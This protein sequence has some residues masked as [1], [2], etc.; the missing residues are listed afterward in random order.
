MKYLLLL[1]LL[2]LATPVTTACRHAPP[3]ASP[4]AVIAFQGT[5]VIKA[6][7]LIRD[8]AVDGNAQTPPLISTGTTRKVVTYHR[9]AITLVHDIPSGWKQ[10]LLDGL[11]EIVKDLP[12][13]EG[14]KL[15][16]Y[17]GLIKAVLAE[18]N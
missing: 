18:V 13:G 2:F 8:F 4:Q 1:S 15:A 7:D 10:T 17:V 12:A 16:P 11:D 5:R 14:Q 9:S 3:S 6:L